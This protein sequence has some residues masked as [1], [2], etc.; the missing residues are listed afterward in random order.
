MKYEL[1]S[2]GNESWNKSNYGFSILN[3]RKIEIKFGPHDNSNDFFFWK[4]KRTYL[5]PCI[6]LQNEEGLA[7]NTITIETCNMIVNI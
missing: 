1:T 5:T 4:V 3:E 2:L 7:I 6:N